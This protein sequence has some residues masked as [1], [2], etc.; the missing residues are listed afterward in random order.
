MAI[1]SVSLNA[2]DSKCISCGA[3]GTGLEMAEQ[4]RLRASAVS[5]LG[6]SLAV[7][8][9]GSYFA[10]SG[11]QER[12]TV[13]AMIKNSSTREKVR[14]GHNLIEHKIGWLRARSAVPARGS[15]AAVFALAAAIYLRLFAQT[16]QA[17]LAVTEFALVKPRQS[18]S[19]C[20]TSPRGAM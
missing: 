11:H 8:N 5:T 6:T 1:L 14:F 9:L 18:A 15:F 12:T 2:V 16:K 20:Q 10:R 7:L 3:N 13:H 4:R 19:T 17:R